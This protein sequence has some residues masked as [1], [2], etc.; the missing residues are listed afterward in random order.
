MAVELGYY[1]FWEDEPLTCPHCGWTGQAGDGSQEAHTE[2]FDVSCPRCD[3]MLLIVSY[4]T[5]DETTQAAAAGN[6]AAKAELPRI[7]QTQA[8]WARAAELA[9]K[10]DSVL[11]DLHGAQLRF[12]WDF[13]EGE[14]ETWTI[15]KHAERIVWRELAYWEGWK[16]F[17]EVKCLLKS[18]YGAA[19]VSL[20][21]TAASEMYLFGD[22]LRA[23]SRI[24]TT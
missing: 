22:S 4:P 17:N 1:D 13:A 18:H 24:E 21:P 16:R 10:P 6:E 14:A 15:I 9:L 23:A 19:F 5:I 7:E 20:E 3:K 11:P 2:L 8:R 12:V